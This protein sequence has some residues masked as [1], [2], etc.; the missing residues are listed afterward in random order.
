MTQP[1][2]DPLVIRQI[3]P[4]KK[5]RWRWPVAGGIAAVLLLGAAAGLLRGA[6]AGADARWE[7]ALLEQGGLTLGVTAVGYLEPTHTAEVGSDQSGRIARVLVAEN[8]TVTEGQ[9]LAELDTEALTLAVRQAEARVAQAE[10]TLAQAEAS[11]AQAERDA[12]R[13]ARMRAQGASSPSEEETASTGAETAAAAL[14]LAQAQVKDARVTLDLA[15]HNRTEAILR[16]PLTG[17]VLTR[18]VEPGQTVVS[19]LQAATLFEIAADL[20]EMHLP[21]EVDEAEVGR[22]QPGQTATFTVPAWVDR[23]FEATVEKVHIAP[24]PDE[25][26]VSY[27]AELRV[28]NP[29]LALRPGMTATAHI[30]TERLD[31]ALSVPAEALRFTPTGEEE[32][33]GA[34]IWVLNGAELRPV[35]VEMLGND[36]NRAAVAGEG[37]AVGTVVALADRKKA[38]R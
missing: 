28:E 1:S 4:Q 29:D 38:P 3:R 5:R 26:V 31:A 6:P 9:V 17:T 14:A 35:E 30:V 34:R 2:P 12:G 11:A 16:S 7:T 13:T 25:Q 21:V 37:F 18:S 36:G 27:I 8:D 24:K 15:R 32:S 23:T 10:A 19:A 22:V 20:S 33:G